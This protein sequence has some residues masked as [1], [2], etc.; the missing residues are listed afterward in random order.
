MSIESVQAGF[1]ERGAAKQFGI[2]P[3]TL[4]QRLKGCKTKS[5]A[6][7]GQQVFNNEQEQQL[8]EYLLKSAKIFYGLTLPQLR[9]LAFQ[10]AQALK[11][12]KSIKKITA[13]SYS[14]NQ[15]EQPAASRDWSEAFLK[16]HPDLTLRRPVPTS[17]GRAIAFNAHVVGEFFDLYENIRQSHQYTAATV[18]NMD[19]TGLNTVHKM[20]YVI[21]QKGE[22][23]VA[24][25]SSG[26]RGTNVTLT[27]AISAAGEKIPP[28]FI[29]PRIKMNKEE[30]AIRVDTER[31]LLIL[32]NHESHLTIEGLEFCK[33]NNIDILTLP[34]HTSHKLQPLD[35]GVFG[36]L[37]AYY[38][39]QC[40]AWLFIH[41]NVPIGI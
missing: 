39:N 4:R 24:A 10:F 28:F 35:K 20:K 27:M 12:A 31:T 17:L 19:E 30:H 11:A 29:F 9:Q 8:R 18:W 26:E 3:Q 37:K 5:E 36:P 21:A 23:C 41:P 7:Y 33:R 16:R 25:A 14:N 1:S 38:A 34:P 22:R 40:S 6:H 32:D 15:D 13:S 2:S